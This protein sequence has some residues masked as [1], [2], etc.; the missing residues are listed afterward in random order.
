MLYYDYNI[1][2]G[3]TASVVKIQYNKTHMSPKKV[4][5]KNCEYNN[6]EYNNNI[7]DLAGKRTNYI[8]CLFA[9]LLS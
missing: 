2:I 7:T 3:V 8:I 1:V 4:L 6:C 5:N 9:V